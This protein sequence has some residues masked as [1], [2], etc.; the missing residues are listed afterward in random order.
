MTLTAFEVSAAEASSDRPDRI[1]STS[2]R[3]LTW[4]AAL[5]SVMSVRWAG[6][7]LA[8]FLTGLV[9]QLNGAAEPVWWTLYLACYLAG[10]WGSAWAGAQA[11]RNRALDVDLLMIVAAIGA[12]AI[13]QIFDGALLIVIFATSGAL[14]DV[15]TKHT[16]D[17]V[18]GLLDL[19]PEQATVFDVDGNEQVVAASELVVGDR[20]VVRPG[21][22]AV[23]SGCSEVDQCSITGESMPAAKG[24][25]DEV[26]AGTVNGSGVLQLLVTRDP[27]QTVVARIVELVSE[28]SAT[29]AKTQLFIEKIEQRYSIGVVIAT[30]ALIAIPLMLGTPVQVVLLRA[31][32]FMIVASPCAVV[33]ATMPPL[34]SAIANAG[35][36][37]VLVKSAIVVEHLADTGVVALDKTG[38]LTFGLPQLAIVEPLSAD[39][40]IKKLLQL[41]AAAEQS[42]EHPLGR[43]IVEEVRRRGITIPGAEDFR[44]L[45]GRGVRAS[46]GREFVE[47]CSPHSY[48]GAPLPELAPILEAGATAAIVLRNGVAIG[49]L[50]LTDQ[51]RADAAPSVAALTALTSAP[52]VLL[53]GDNPCAAQRVAQHAGITDVRAALLPEQKV[54]AV[55]ALQASGHRVLVVGDGVND[56]PAMAAAHTSVAM[57]A[58]ADLTLQT[59]DGVTVRDELHTI[60][61]LIGLARQARRVVTA[62]LF[63]AGTFISVLVLWD[64]FGQLPLPLGVA[65]HEGSTVLVAL[66]GMR[67]LTNR[68]WRAAASPVR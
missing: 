7:A 34:L 23:L 37:G 67:L 31:M 20:V 2:V 58:G 14:D 11:L 5:W 40:G 48:R 53:T 59:A 35:R 18:K 56:A 33:L 16:A 42:S 49:V 47:V 12:V 39:V 51:V 64:L 3:P 32:T 26:F 45:P 17:S 63:I 25:G 8:L 19:A 27:S 44:A 28:A 1:P 10:G 21:D 52:P 13:G 54:E 36:H 55:Q 24:R 4:R 62:N 41:A 6:I 38:T 50:G 46:V 15:A 68:S 30:L 43:A 66:N 22:G 57:G 60:P 61:T 9:A 65:G 29:K